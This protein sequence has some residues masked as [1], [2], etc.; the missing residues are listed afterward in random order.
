VRY[1]PLRLR[2]LPVV[3]TGTGRVTPLGSLATFM[4][5]QSRISL[6]RENQQQM[7]ALPPTSAGGRSAA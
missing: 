5:T 2:A 4:S 3:A 6:E 7:I 1:N